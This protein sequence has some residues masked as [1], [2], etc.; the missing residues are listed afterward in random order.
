M[1]KL[2]K[3]LSPKSFGYLLNV[4]EILKDEGIDIR[5]I[6]V[7]I[8]IGDGKTRFVTLSDIE[9]KGIDMQAIIKKYDL[10]KDYYIGLKIHH[11]REACSGRGT[12]RITEE[13]KKMAQLMG[14]LTKKRRAEEFLEIL[15]VL[16][17]EN[18]D[19]SKMITLRYK[20]D[21]RVRFKLKEIK[22][23]GINIEEI[24]EKNNLDENF[25]ID[26]AIKK[27][28][29]SDFEKNGVT[30]SQ[31]EKAKELG[32]L[33][34]KRGYVDT[35]EVLEL[36]KS[37]GVDVRM[38]RVA[39]NV[40]GVKSNTVLREIK[41][42]G[43]DIEKIM[44]KYYLDGDYPIGVKISELR[45]V[46]NGRRDDIVFTEDEKTRI[47]ELGIM[48]KKTSMEE[49]L[50]ILETLKSEN[51][52]IHLIRKVKGYDFNGKVLYNCIRDI[53]DDRIDEIIKKYDLDK[54][55]PIGY[56]IDT[57]K[58]AYIGKGLTVLTDKDRSRAEELGVIKIS[59]LEKKQN[60]LKET[61]E[62]AKEL[63]ESV[64]GQHKK[65]IER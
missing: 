63:K 45:K 59:E 5:K 56:K 14:I 40:N 39:K 41:Q 19:L 36:L 54:E 58:K 61:L 6:K 1:L 16:K 30:K 35:I 23:Y 11:L 29:K 53:E 34:N 4:L 2:N 32:I 38:I 22:Q 57:L 24:I 17:K 37:E 25:S 12:C 49:L 52:K 3:E 31:K 60:Q 21:K 46:N 8:S 47:E 51:I 55:Y 15:E 13:E 9:Q 10:N 26:K 20:D 28:R 42:Y 50:D 64:E 33:D 18:V 43:I 27:I 65:H 48:E 44:K 62:E 7:S